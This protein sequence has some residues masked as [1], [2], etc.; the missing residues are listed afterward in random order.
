MIVADRNFEDYRNRLIRFWLYSVM[1]L[2][3]ALFVL[4]TAQAM[5]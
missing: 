2:F 5:S 1:K 3:L 4:M